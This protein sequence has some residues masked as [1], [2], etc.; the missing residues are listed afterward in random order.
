MYLFRIL[1]Q[2]ISTIV[3]EVCSAIVKSLSK[4]VKTPSTPE[5]WQLGAT[6]YKAYCSNCNICQFLPSSI[7]WH[8]TFKSSSLSLCCLLMTLMLCCRHHLY[9]CT[10]FFSLLL[11]GSNKGFRFVQ[12][13]EKRSFFL[14]LKF[15]TH[16]GEIKEN[17]KFLKYKKII[18]QKWNTDIQ[19]KT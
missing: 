3:P 19:N 8:E 2:S 18:C 1:K 10:Y 4:D 9:V 16:I 6:G 17:A 7:L 15:L 12:F 5:E 14:V 11:W 13:D